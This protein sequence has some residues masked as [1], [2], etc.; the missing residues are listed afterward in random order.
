MVTVH[1]CG[2]VLMYCTYNYGKSLE[3]ENVCSFIPQS[4]LGGP[5]RNVHVDALSQIDKP[6][7]NCKSLLHSIVPTTTD[8]AI[9]NL[10][11]RSILIFNWVAS[12]S[13]YGSLA[14]SQWVRRSLLNG[15][16]SVSVGRLKFALGKLINLCPSIIIV[17]T[18]S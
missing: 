14:L 7:Y 8:T 17:Y 4:V 15:F 6:L 3:T 5:K 11:N 13:L 2:N 12:R 18:V 16:D 9:E 1:K 10:I